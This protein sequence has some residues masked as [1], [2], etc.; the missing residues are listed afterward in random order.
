MHRDTARCTARKLATG[1]LV[2][3]QET[4]PPPGRAPTAH[5]HVDTERFPRR[6]G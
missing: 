3:V 5:H 2:E 1:E 4:T 6:C